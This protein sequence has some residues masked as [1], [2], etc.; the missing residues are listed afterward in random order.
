MMMKLG[1]TACLGALLACLLVAGASAAE[2][3]LDKDRIASNEKVT[4]TV[5]DLADGTHYSQKTT[6]YQYMEPGMPSAF[7]S[8]NITWPFVHAD[9]VFSMSNQ[10]TTQNLVYIGHWW[11]E[12]RG[13]GYEDGLWTGPSK[14][15]AWSDSVHYG[16]DQTGTYHTTWYADPQKDARI[17][18]STFWINGTKTSGSDDFDEEL[19]FWTVNP[20]VVEIEWYD[21][22]V[23]H[24]TVSFELDAID[25]AHFI[26][27]PDT[28]KTGNKIGF[29]LIP[30]SG[31]TVKSTW[32]SFDAENHLK[33]W[34]S[35]ARNPNFFYPRWASGFQSP[36]VE[37][38]Y[39][40][41]STE[42]V[43][44]TDYVNVISDRIPRTRFFDHTPN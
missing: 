9:D 34:N 2:V 11:P 20:A 15:G 44:L 6:V 42:K 30:A 21:N 36:L 24:D 38:T 22:N 23:L 25:G 37:I 4:A 8:K 17:V 5:T 3:S 28:L 40:D 19:E 16:D 31:K 10:N 13:G 26:A 32:W 27:V 18:T 1:Y 41:G 14:K 7:G 29:K 43:E 35:R 39:K 12:N 33:T